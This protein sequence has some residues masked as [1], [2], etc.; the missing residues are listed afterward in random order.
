MRTMATG[1]GRHARFWEEPRGLELA[2]ARLLPGG[3]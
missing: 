1:A 3:R 2:A